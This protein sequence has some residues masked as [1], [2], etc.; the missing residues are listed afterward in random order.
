MQCHSPNTL[1][2]ISSSPSVLSGEKLSPPG[3]LRELVKTTEIQRNVEGVARVQTQ[4][5]AR[6]E[7]QDFSRIGNFPDSKTID[8][9]EGSQNRSTS[10]SGE[11]VIV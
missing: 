9:L 5:L 10:S 2:R 3:L 6:P 11:S 8:T 7:A 4:G 1:R